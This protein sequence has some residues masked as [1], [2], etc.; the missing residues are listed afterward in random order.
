MKKKP[1]AEIFEQ[2]ARQVPKLN[3]FRETMPNKNTGENREIF[4]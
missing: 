2:L 4:R 1:E 3:S